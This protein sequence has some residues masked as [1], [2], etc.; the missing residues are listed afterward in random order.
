MEAHAS[1]SLVPPLTLLDTSA[2]E[3]LVAQQR[4][5]EREWWRVACDKE[6]E[7]AIRAKERARQREREEELALERERDEELTHYFIGTT[8]VNPDGS[9]YVS[10]S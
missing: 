3:I 6:R 4:A 2:G 5:L 10:F 8:R 1:S 9:L 7:R